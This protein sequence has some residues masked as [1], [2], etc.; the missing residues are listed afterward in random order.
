MLG[1]SDHH[2]GVS[3][4]GMCRDIANDAQGLF[5]IIDFVSG[6]GMLRGTMSNCRMNMISSGET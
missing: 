1:T 3:T 4:I 6:G 2:Q 5:L